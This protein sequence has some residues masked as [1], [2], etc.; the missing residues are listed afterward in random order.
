[1]SGKTGKFGRQCSPKRCNSKEAGDPNG[2][3]FVATGNGVLSNR[4]LLADG[5]SVGDSHGVGKSVQER[6][7]QAPDRMRTVDRD[8]DRSGV[9]SRQVVDAPTGRGTSAFDGCQH[10]QP[11]RE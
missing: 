9:G 8:V 6:G 11:T 10:G 2:L 4:L 7:P 5:G 3:E 1:M